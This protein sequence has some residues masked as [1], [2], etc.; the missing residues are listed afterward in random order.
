M[1]VSTVVPAARP[2]PGRIGPP[3]AGR[4]GVAL[5]APLV[6]A[7]ALLVGVSV[8]GVSAVGAP[9]AGAVASGTHLLETPPAGQPAGAAPVAGTR[10]TPAAGSSRELR[11]T[12]PAL[13]DAV[14]VA[15]TTTGASAGSLPWGD[16]GPLAD[17]PVPSSAGPPGR[18]LPRPARAAAAWAAHPVRGPPA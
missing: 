14:L 17:R 4:P 12:G 10:T 16:V 7:L 2:R 18:A 8:V 6:V 15:I 3:T 1:S 5:L 11:G 9:A 13:P